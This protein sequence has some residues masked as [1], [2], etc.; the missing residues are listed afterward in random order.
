MLCFCSVECCL[1]FPV[2]WVFFWD[3]ERVLWEEP[4]LDSGVAGG[5]CAPAR[6]YETGKKN[7]CKHTKGSMMSLGCQERGYPCSNV[8]CPDLCWSR[9]S[10][11]VRNS[12]WEGNRDTVGLVPTDGEVVL[13]LEWDLCPTPASPIAFPDCVKKCF[14]FRGKC[15]HSEISV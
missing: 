11:N 4:I 12:I 5:R 6:L 13:C 15:S 3:V 14:D 1:S 8:M 10:G 9:Q 2:I 7:S